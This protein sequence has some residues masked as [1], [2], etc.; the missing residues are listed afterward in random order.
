MTQIQTLYQTGDATWPAAEFL[1]IGNWTIRKGAGGGQR[2]SS[3]TANGPVTSADI[4]LAE[5]AMDALEQNPLFMVREGEEALDALLDAKGY[6]IKDIVNLY[7]CPIENITRLAPECITA[8]PIWPPLAIINE[9]WSEHGIGVERQAVMHR[10]HAPK[11]TILARHNDRAAGVAYV[12]IHN[13]MAM[14]H[15]LEVVNDHR[16]QGV[17]NNI[18]G[19]AA[20]WAQDNGATDFSIICVRDNVAANTLY[21]SLD[22]ENVGHYHY[23]I[24]DRKRATQV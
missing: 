12:A 16:R 4:N 18:L 20:I 17:A 13:S 7:T 8:Y 15:A 21:T 22:M 14:L 3:T 6:R 19:A 10:A 1:T 11:T 2:V 5:E 23:R 9:I 24:K